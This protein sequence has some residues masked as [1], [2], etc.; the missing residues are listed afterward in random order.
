MVEL[1]YTIQETI[2][3]KGYNIAGKVD[4]TKVQI[5]QFMSLVTGR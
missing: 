5:L 4:A 1:G 2:T 3:L